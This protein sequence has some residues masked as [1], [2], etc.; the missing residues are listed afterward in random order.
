MKI[1]YLVLLVGWFLFLN[2]KTD[3]QKLDSEEFHIH[4]SDLNHSFQK[5]QKEKSG[6][7]VFLGGSITHNPGWRDSVCR[8]LQQKFPETNFDFINAGIPSMGSTPG[9]FRF[10]RD[11]L[12]NGPVDLLFVE[13]AVNDDT[14]R[15]TP[16]EITRGM[17]GIIRH[18]KTAN[19]DCDIIIMYFVDP[20]KMIDY[21][22]REVPEV[23]Q[24]HEKVARHYGI[25]I[26]NLAKEVTERIDT[27]EFSWDDDFKDLHPSPFGQQ[28]YFY[29]MKSFLETAIEVSE[30]NRQINMFS[31]PDPIDVYS[32]ANGHLVEPNPNKRIKG[33]EMIEDWNPQDGKGTRNNYVNVPM[34][35]GEYPG[36]IIKF[37]FKGNA[38]GIAVAA[39]P[40][41]GIIEYS[42]DN[43]E[44]EKQDLFTQWSKGLYLPWYYTLAAGLKDG[45]HILQIRM[46]TERNAESIGRKCILRYFYF[47]G[48]EK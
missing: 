12:K 31:I 43:S 22:N 39:G 36:K 10:E 40:D 3:A 33:W 42:I 13:A 41:A 8:F 46:T 38:V 27:K 23:I 9:A 6:R 14:N 26:I 5:F 25:S 24:L 11:V 44:W 35:V 29:S 19:P 45:N 28:V 37:H 17:E 1:Y 30:N 47:N 4:R 32:Y 21:R 34:L 7:V 18:A 20:G 2:V 16:E 15:R 48:V